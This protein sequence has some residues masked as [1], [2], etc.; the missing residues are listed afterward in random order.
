[1]LPRIEKDRHDGG[2]AGREIGSS[3]SVVYG[4]R[5]ASRM[6]GSQLIMLV[7]L[8]AY[9]IALYTINES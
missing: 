3:G 7:S 2:V 5:S 6:E 4:S 9:N 8:I 1:M